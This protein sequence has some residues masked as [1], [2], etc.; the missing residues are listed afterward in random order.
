MTFFFGA[1]GLAVVVAVV[2]AATVVVAPVVVAAVVFVVGPAP[3]ETG[4][5]EPFTCRM[6]PAGSP[7][8]FSTMP[9]LPPAWQLHGA[10]VSGTL[11]AT[12]LP[13]IEHEPDTSTLTTPVIVNPGPGT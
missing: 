5:C 10:S 1:G 2:V 11:H 3:T 13:D 12:F 7:L 4:N 8:P 9:A 6:L